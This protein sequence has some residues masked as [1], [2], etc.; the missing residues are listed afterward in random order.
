MSLIPVKTKSL[1]LI[2]IEKKSHQKAYLYVLHRWNESTSFYSLHSSENLWL[3][4][5]V[6][7]PRKT[8][9]GT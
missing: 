7:T 5:C 2:S 9:T 4:R 1:E 3:L 6:S 8:L